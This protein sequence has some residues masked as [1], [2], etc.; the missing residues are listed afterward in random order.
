M[1]NKTIYDQLRAVGMT[2]EGACGLM[3][4]MQAESSMQANI[5][6]R[7]MTTL[8]DDVYT[9]AADRGMIDF[10]HDSVGYGLCQWTYWSRKQ[11]LLSFAADSG[12]SVGDEDTQVQFCVKELRE[13][14]PNV[15]VVLT[16]SHD[17][18]ECARIVCLQYE[19]P[20]VNNVDKRYRFAQDFFAQLADGSDPDPAPD[21]QPEPSPQPAE[22]PASVILLQL[23]ME[24]D[25]YWHA[26]V[27]G[28]K[29]QEF[30]EQI[31]KY[32]AD[33]AAC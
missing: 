2:A 20:A 1:S 7:G 8:A 28:I 24:R 3:G 13:D 22:V 14:F 16:G 15:W 4:N 18:Y 19:R 30:R 31:K 29:S 17:L 5:A 9:A 6:Q 33:V 26:P 23:A 21:P 32:A 10:V 27:D 25:G 12:V 11:G